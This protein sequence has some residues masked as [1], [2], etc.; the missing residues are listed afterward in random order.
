MRSDA[1]ARQVRLDKIEASAAVSA[2]VP[3]TALVNTVGRAKISWKK[4][5]SPVANLPGVLGNNPLQIRNALLRGSI[6]R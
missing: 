1:V 4:S 3:P 5:I 2:A 6:T